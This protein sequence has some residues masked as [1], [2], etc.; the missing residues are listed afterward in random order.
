M[1]LILMR[2][3][4]DHKSRDSDRS[5]GDSR[6]SEESGGEDKQVA[7]GSAQIQSK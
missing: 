4:M 5:D 1:M 6:D 2:M 3:C 7:A